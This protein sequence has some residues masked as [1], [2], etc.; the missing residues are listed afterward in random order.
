MDGI[1]GEDLITKIFSLFCFTPN[2]L[3]LLLNVIYFSV[4]DPRVMLVLGNETRL[5][6][7]PLGG[8]PCPWH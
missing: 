7:V 1:S 5:E 4:D 6:L 8:C 3:C 2:G